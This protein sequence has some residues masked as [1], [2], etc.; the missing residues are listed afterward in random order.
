MKYTTKQ[1]NT[2]YKKAYKESSN[3]YNTGLYIC[4]SFGRVVERP[5][6]SFSWHFTYKWVSILPEFGL[7]EPKLMTQAGWFGNKR[8]NDNK[9]ERLTALAF[10]IAMTEETK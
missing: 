9:N 2:I 10:M 7:F 6:R 4:Q 3:C 5:E 8:I 1:R